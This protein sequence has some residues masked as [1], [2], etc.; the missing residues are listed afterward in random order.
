MLQARISLEPFSR[1]SM[2]GTGWLEEPFI[3]RQI[4]LT[5]LIVG[6]AEICMYLIETLVLVASSDTCRLQLLIRLGTNVGQFS[7]HSRSNLVTVRNVVAMVSLLESDM[8]RVLHHAIVSMPFTH[9]GELHLT[10]AVF[11]PALQPM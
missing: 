7:C 5:N 9:L 8:I 4:A 6:E 2:S 10:L 1:W 11:H 3:P